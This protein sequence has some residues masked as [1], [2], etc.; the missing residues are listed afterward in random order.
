MAEIQFLLAEEDLCQRLGGEAPLEVLLV[1]FFT[2]EDRNQDA[3]NDGDG[4]PDIRISRDPLSE[5]II[6]DIPQAYYGDE[7]VGYAHVAN[8]C[9]VTMANLEQTEMHIQ[10]G[11]SRRKIAHN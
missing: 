5:T 2:E 8:W 9:D 11:S 6:W 3:I 7:R 10:N 1:S 4:V